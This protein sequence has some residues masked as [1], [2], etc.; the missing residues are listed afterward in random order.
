MRLGQIQGAMLPSL[1]FT[2]ITTTLFFIEALNAQL[3]HL[4]LM[5]QH[6]YYNKLITRTIF[7]T[8]EI[9]FLLILKQE[10]LNEARLCKILS[11]YINPTEANTNPHGIVSRLSLHHVNSSQ[12]LPRL[13][14]PT[15]VVQDAYCV[16][17]E[18]SLGEGWMQRCNIMSGWFEVS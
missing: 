13:L 6:S 1:I 5:N 11:P 17:A 18:A 10:T 12:M 4:Q 14:L 2:E 8:D 15:W 16:F 3:H 9:D 7:S